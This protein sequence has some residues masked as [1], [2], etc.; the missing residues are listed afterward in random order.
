M[1]DDDFRPDEMDLLADWLHRHPESAATFTEP[2]DVVVAQ[3]VAQVAAAERRRA[4]AR[5]RR[6]RRI[7]G[8]AILAVVATGG[9][10]TAAALLNR[11]EPSRPE[12]GTVC[13]AAASF[14][15]DAVVIE[16]GLDP[17]DGCRHQWENGAFADSGQAGEVPNLVACVDPRGPINVFPGDENTCGQL[18]LAEAGPLGE[19]EQQAVELDEQITE[20]NG[21]PCTTATDFTAAVVDVFAKSGESDWSVVLSP[22]AENAPCVLAAVDSVTRTVTLFDPSG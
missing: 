19:R 5:R 21:G 8:G 1:S 22:G 16:P 7:A 3:V 12:A 2:D 13:R 6:R 4:G 20:M 15:A 10:V 11:G 14:D 18:G 17:L 9:A